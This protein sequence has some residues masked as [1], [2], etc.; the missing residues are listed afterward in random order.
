MDCTSISS[1][2]VLSTPVLVLNRCW[3]PVHVTSARRA[4][5]L[6]YQAAARVVAPDTL[7]LHDFDEWVCLPDPP[8]NL[9]L[10]GVRIRF[11]VEQQVDRHTSIERS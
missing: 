2:R 6:V 9:W 4:L 11:G 5:C 1:L 7:Q 10:R 8:T 3:V